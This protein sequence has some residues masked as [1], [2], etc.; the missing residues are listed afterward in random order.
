MTTRFVIAARAG[1]IERWFRLR[2]ESAEAVCSHVRETTGAEVSLQ[3]TIYSADDP[4]IIERL[5]DVEL[6]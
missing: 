1:A 4:V 3:A 6:K 5:R 2:G